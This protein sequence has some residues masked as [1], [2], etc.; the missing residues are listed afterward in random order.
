MSVTITPKSATSSIII[1]AFFGANVQ[2]TTTGSRTG[3]YK[4]T[5][6]S[7]NGISGAENIEFG[8]INSTSGIAY[9]KYGFLSLRAYVTTGSTSAVTY[10]LRFSAVASNVTTS[11]RNDASTG[12]MFA[13]EVSA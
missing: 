9:L 10:K 11:V 8:F 3:S 12:Q 7:N 5:D 6:S 4:L 13:T 2:S 1:E